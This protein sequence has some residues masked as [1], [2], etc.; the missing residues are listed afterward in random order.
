MKEEITMI[1]KTFPIH[2]QDMN[3]YV[4]RKSGNNFDKNLVR[5]YYMF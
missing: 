4:L 5:A 3:L 2:V 1:D